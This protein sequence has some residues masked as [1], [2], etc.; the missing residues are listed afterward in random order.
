MLSLPN[1]CS[2][3]KIS[4]HPKT[5]K[6]GRHDL[7][8]DWYIHYRF[9]DPSA[10]KPKQVIIK[11]MNTFKDLAQ[12]REAT[13]TLLDTE[14]DLLINQG[15]NPISG[16]IIKPVI[17]DSD[18]DTSTPFI[19]ALWMAHKVL[20][21]APSTKSDISSVIRGVEKASLQLGISSLPISMVTRKHIKKIF[22]QCKTVVPGWSAGRYNKY[23]AYLKIVFGELIECEATEI[24]PLTRI[25][26]QK[27]TRKLRLVLTI[28]E[29]KKVNAYL[30]EKYYHFWRFLQIFFHSGAREAELMRL[31]RNDVDLAGQRYKLTIRKGFE[32]T[33]VWK[34]IKNVALPFWTELINEATGNQ[35]LFSAGLRPGDKMISPAQIT[36][37]WRAHVKEKLK[38]TADFYSLKHLN[39]DE[40]AAALSAKDASTMASHTTPVITIGHYLH[41]E[42]ERQNERLKAV[43]NSFG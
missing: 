18:I 31:R 14:T 43:E 9:Y 12:R 40:T 34:V 33:E 42:T 19:P 29:R 13:Q 22:A 16:R 25:K 5:W 27:E 28:A 38:I 11:G 32:N 24:D 37:R 36:R 26:K 20:D 17:T 39:L 41:G 1:G 10:S 2:C 8:K 35:V 23:R 3:S 15:Y 6:K 4:V 7:S 21:K 30:Q